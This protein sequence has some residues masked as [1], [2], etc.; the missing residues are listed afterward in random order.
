MKYLLIVFGTYAIGA[1]IIEFVEDTKENI[2]KYKDLRKQGRGR[3]Y[4][5]FKA[6]L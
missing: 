4:S 3:I 2:G 6:F 1:T 5:F